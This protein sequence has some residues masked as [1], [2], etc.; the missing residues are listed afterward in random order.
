MQRICNIY[1]SKG[2]NLTSSYSALEMNKPGWRPRARSEPQPHEQPR[3]QVVPRKDERTRRRLL[4]SPTRRRELLLGK[5]QGEQ[6]PRG[7]LQQRR[8]SIRGKRNRRAQVPWPLYFVR[9]ARGASGDRSHEEG[10]KET[11]GRSKRKRQGYLF[12]SISFHPRANSGRRSCWPFGRYLS[13]WPTC[14]CAGRT[15]CILFVHWGLLHARFWF[16]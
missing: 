1:R 4:S 9:G 5:P 3:I 7:K 2:A 13:S 8:K 15:T 12:V 14:A 16:Y 11:D 10:M 6:N